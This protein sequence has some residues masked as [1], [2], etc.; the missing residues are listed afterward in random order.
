MTE[1]ASIVEFKNHGIPGCQMV[2]CVVT[3]DGDTF[4][5][6]FREVK[7][8]FV[9]DV[10]TKGGASISGVTA[11]DGAFEVDCTSGDTVYLQVFGLD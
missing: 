1:V 9:N 6:R 4:T 8:A 11:G 5:S 2:S 3:T 7:M 10:T